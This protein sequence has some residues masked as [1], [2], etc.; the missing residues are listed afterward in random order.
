M[1]ITEVF[2]QVTDVS[3]GLWGQR[4]R[5]G[6]TF[7]TATSK[8][9]AGKTGNDPPP[10][11]PRPHRGTYLCPPVL[12]GEQESPEKKEE[13]ERERDRRQEQRG[14]GQGEDRK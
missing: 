11:M 9:P 5:A 7:P 10:H 6:C 14:G 2:V 4:N 8:A 13:E 12:Q 1:A 3:L